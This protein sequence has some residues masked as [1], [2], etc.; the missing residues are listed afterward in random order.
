MQMPDQKDN[1]PD[2]V[3]K[4]TKAHLDSDSLTDWHFGSLS[5]TL[6]LL[7]AVLFVFM[8]SNL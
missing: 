1:I 7:K 2:H 5:V 8:L 6:H 4:H 3:Y